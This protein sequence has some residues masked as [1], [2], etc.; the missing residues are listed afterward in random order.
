MKLTKPTRFDVLHIVE[1]LSQASRDEVY[2]L[3]VSDD[4][5]DLVDE[6]MDTMGHVAFIAW[7]DNP[8]TLIGAIEVRPK[9]WETVMMSTDELGPILPR[10][11]RFAKREVLPFIKNTGAR[12]IST[13]T[14]STHLQALRWAR[15]LGIPFVVD[16]PQFGRNG[17]KFTLSRWTLPDVL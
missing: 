14:L 5:D 16:L 12:S 11:T 7:R 15:L 9:A 17:E 6:I 4:P 2:A 1:N 3:Q 13:Y 8:V 10:L